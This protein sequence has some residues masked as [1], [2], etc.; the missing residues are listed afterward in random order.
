MKGVLMKNN[1]ELSIVI[2]SFNTK[3]LLRNCLNSLLAL[4]NEA[5]FEI[6]VSDNGSTD[7]SVE[8][9]KKE[10]PEVKLIENNQNFGFAKGNNQA[11]S[12]CRGKY[13]LFLNSDTVIK[14]LA[15]KK[16]LKYLRDNLEVGALSC[17]LILPNGKLDK[18]VRRSFVTPWIG[19]THIF[20]K[21]DRIFPKSKLF[22]RYWY[23][24]ISDNEIQNVDAIQGAYF[25]TSRKILDKV[26]WFDED[27]FL[28]GEDIDLCWKIKKLGLKIIY[29]PEVYITHIKG[30][31][32]GK[33]SF[34]LK[35]SLK[36]KLKFRMSGVNS[37]EIFYRKRLWQ[38]YPLFLNLLT[39]LGIKVLKLIRFTTVI[40]SS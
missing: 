26:D 21:L 17:K 36:E 20:L 16:P 24:Y 10:F 27:Y 3:E 18:D 35:M 34:G 14:P 23:G 9:L 38:K 29:Y 30:A 33:N 39:I 6:I 15:I 40:L 37:M 12:F 4:K 11:K 13:I 28:D 22:A 25:L 1:P 8:M 31:S 2:L 19:L 5:D 7:S 32:K